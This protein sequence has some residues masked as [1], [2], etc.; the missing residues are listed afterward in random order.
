M[1]ATTH[2][3][4]DFPIHNSEIPRK[5]LTGLFFFNSVAS[6]QALIIYYDIK[7][8]SLHVQAFGSVNLCITFPL[9]ANHLKI[10]FIIV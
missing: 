1:T 7:T 4:S 9:K 2:Q 5:K 8:I 3:S 10:S 6:G